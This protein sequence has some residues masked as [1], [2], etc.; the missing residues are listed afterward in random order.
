MYSKVLDLCLIHML[1]NINTIHVLSLIR[2]VD[3]VLKKKKTFFKK[4]RRTTKQIKI[5]S[6]SKRAVQ[7]WSPVLDCSEREK[8][9]FVKC[10]EYL[11]VLSRLLFSNGEVEL[12]PY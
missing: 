9:I 11:S 5:G 2:S 6:T 3:L 8:I 1:F 12:K 7:F 4:R 10:E